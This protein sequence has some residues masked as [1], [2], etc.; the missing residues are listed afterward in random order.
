VDGKNVEEAVGSALKQLNVTEDKVTIEV[1]EE[2][3]KG[4]LNLIGVKPAK[5]K[6]TLKR[7]YIEDARKFVRDVLDSMGVLAEIR[8]SEENDTIKIDLTGPKMGI[9]IGYR[10]ETLDSLQYLISLVVNK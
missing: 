10:G 6:V 8:I 1:L 4:F 9:I 7:D 2:G 3:S 5:V